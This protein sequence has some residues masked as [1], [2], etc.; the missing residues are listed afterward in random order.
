MPHLGE[1]A[2]GWWGVGVVNWELDVSLEEQT[3]VQSEHLTDLYR[4]L[5]Q[6]FEPAGK[7]NKTG[8]NKLQYL[9]HFYWAGKKK[10]IF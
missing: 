7:Q 6:S 1:E 3:D 8:P 4:V 5:F 2:K 9:L 10:N